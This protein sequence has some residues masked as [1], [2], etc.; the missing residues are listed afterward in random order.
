MYHVGWADVSIKLPLPTSSLKDESLHL[1]NI[2]ALL[3]H[4]L[5]ILT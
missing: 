2:N 3:R 5:D 4:G 1:E